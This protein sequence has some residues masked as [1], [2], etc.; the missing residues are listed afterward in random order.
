M[1]WRSRLHSQ[2]SLGCHIHHVSLAC[3]IHIYQNHGIA[4]VFTDMNMTSNR[5]SWKIQCVLLQ[6]KMCGYISIYMNVYQYLPIYVYSCIQQ[7]SCSINTYIVTVGPTT[8]GHCAKK[9]KCL[10][11]PLL[12]RELIHQQTRKSC[13][14]RLSPLPDRN[15][16][17]EAIIQ[18]L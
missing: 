5:C 6:T 4:I 9:K 1:M 12:Q 15:S 13:V 3:T 17:K 14:F 8:I 10:T 16:H 2:V 11:F 7:W 18:F